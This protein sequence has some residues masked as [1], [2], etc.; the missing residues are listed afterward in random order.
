M[1]PKYTRTSKHEARWPRRTVKATLAAHDPHMNS[2]R[3]E[4]RQD[5]L[6]ITPP[7]APLLA[8]CSLPSLENHRHK[9]LQKMVGHRESYWLCV[10]LLCHHYCHM[11]SCSAQR[12]GWLRAPELECLRRTT[13]RMHRKTCCTCTKTQIS[14]WSCLELDTRQI[15]IER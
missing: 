13:L 8:L 6:L 9:I 11:L 7:D 2:D 3:N 5:F 12:G 10:G 1:I 15:D 14:R 4:I